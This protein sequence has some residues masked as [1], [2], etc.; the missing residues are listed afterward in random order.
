MMIIAADIIDNLAKYGFFFDSSS[1]TIKN[2]CPVTNEK[3][4]LI[5]HQHDLRKSKKN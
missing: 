4:S 2:H 5:F 1:T 3:I